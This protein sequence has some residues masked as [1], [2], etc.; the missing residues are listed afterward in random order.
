MCGPGTGIAPFRAF[1]QERASTGA[2]AVECLFR[3]APHSLSS[4]KAW[5][6]KLRISEVGPLHWP[7]IR[8]NQL[9]FSIVVPMLILVH[10]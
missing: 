1:L 4:G 8:V 6:R 2:T 7:M 3:V 9:Q 5:A 10:L